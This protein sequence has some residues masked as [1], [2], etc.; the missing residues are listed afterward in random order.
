[1]CRCLW[2]RQLA[3]EAWL[4]LLAHLSLSLFLSGI[5]EAGVWA[6]LCGLLCSVEAQLRRRMYMCI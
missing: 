5:D 3:S 4:L 2:R 6:G 1:M